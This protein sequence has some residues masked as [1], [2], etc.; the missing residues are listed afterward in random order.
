ME[1]LTLA[2]LFGEN[3]V[4]TSPTVWRPQLSIGVFMPT[5]GLANVIMSQLQNDSY[6][7]VQIQSVETFLQ[8]MAQERH[9]LD[10][11]V[12]EDNPDLLLLSQHLQEQSL[13]VPV[14]II[15]SQ[16]QPTDTLI[17][18]TTNPSD[19]YKPEE[20]SSQYL[21]HCT[22]VRI[23]NNQLNQI[24]GYIDQAI[25]QFITHAITARLT[26]QSASGNAPTELTNF[27]IRQQRRLVS[28][29]HERLGYLGVYYKRSPQNFIRN[30]APTERQEFIDQLK[31]KYR[32]IVLSYF[33]ADQSLNNKIDEYVNLAFFADVPVTRIVEIHMELMDNF[34]KQLKLEGRSEDVL[35]DYRLT[36]IDTIA[37]LCEMYRRSIP[38][39]S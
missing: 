15:T 9:Q 7:A 18:T 24:S 11:I 10:C 39:D 25:S 19:T 28:K 22:E 33:S 13:S 12:L 8:F 14:V 3:L 26:E 37:H 17:Q 29:L 38:R 5:L 16:P 6:T 35:L 32:Q 4:S 27:I 31:T 30:L 23:T 1:R 36:L 21:Y 20:D 2:D 34:S